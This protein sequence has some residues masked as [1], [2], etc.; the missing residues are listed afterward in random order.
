MWCSNSSHFEEEISWA[1]GGH[2]YRSFHRLLAGHNVPFSIC[3]F[4]PQE[5]S[6]VTD[7]YMYIV[8]LLVADLYLTQVIQYHNEKCHTDCLYVSG[9]DLASHHKCVFL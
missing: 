8:H 6:V 1:F 3:P 7:I 2:F 5:A 9:Y 4:I